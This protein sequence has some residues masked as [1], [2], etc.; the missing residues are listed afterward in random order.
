VEFLQPG[1]SDHSPAV[2]TIGIEKSFGPNP[3]FKF[4]NF[5]IDNEQF[6]SWV[7]HGWQREV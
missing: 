6:M 4:F 5:C 1:I 2:V 3:F 7:Y